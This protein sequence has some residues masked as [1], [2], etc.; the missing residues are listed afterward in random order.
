M[1]KQKSTKESA[2]KAKRTPSKSP[3][4]QVQK[5]KAAEEDFA[6]PN[7]VI[8]GG[9]HDGGDQDGDDF[10]EPVVEANS[11][12]VAKKSGRGNSNSQNSNTKKKNLASSQ[13]SH[14]SQ[15]SNGKKLDMDIDHE[16]QKIESLGNSNNEINAQNGEEVDF[17]E[18]DN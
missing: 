13:Q 10:V 14:T 2:D 15:Q 6:Q 9:G 7:P 17:K 5:R 16:A 8:G 12:T 1:T 4:K 3:Q 18:G 11:A